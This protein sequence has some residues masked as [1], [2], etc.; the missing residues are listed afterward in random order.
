MYKKTLVYILLFFPFSLLTK[1][2]VRNGYDYN[3]TPSAFCFRP[4]RQK[5]TM[6]RTIAALVVVSWFL[7]HK[8]RK[9]VTSALILPIPPRTKDA[10]RS[11]TC[12]RD[13]LQQQL[14]DVF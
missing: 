11:T 1:R 3:K 6:A 14:N 5:H 12:R 2:E 4:G 13:T 7:G 8:A 10:C 9:Y